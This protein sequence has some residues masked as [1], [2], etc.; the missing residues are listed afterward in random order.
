MKSEDCIDYALGEMPTPRREA[1]ERELAESPELLQSLEETTAWLDTLREAS[2]PTEALDATRREFLLAACRSNISTR[3]RRAKIIRL[4]VPLSLAAVALFGLLLARPGPGP[5]RNASPLGAGSGSVHYE[6][7][8]S[9][10]L[11]ATARIQN[12]ESVLSQ[13]ISNA[14]SLNKIPPG[15]QLEIQKKSECA[16]INV[17]KPA[18]R[19]AV[20]TASPRHT[21]LTEKNPFLDTKK[22]PEVAMPLSDSYES[23]AQIRQDILDGKLP[24]P[25]SIRIDELLN[26]FTYDFD[27]PAVA[28]GPFAVTLEAGKSP[29]NPDRLLVK[30]GLKISDPPAGSDLSSFRDIMLSVR[31]QPA[32]VAS[33]RLI[34]YEKNNAP[35]R[36][37][38]RLPFAKPLTVTAL[39][40]IV[41]HARTA[42]SPHDTLL[43][44]IVH[45]RTPR[46]H[47]CQHMV[48]TCS[49]SGIPPL[50]E[51][52][53][54]YRFAAA[55]AA[56]GMKLAGNPEAENISWS[57]IETL[58]ANSLGADPDGQRADFT[59]LVAKASRLAA[60]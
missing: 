18:P 7:V 40:E 50:E 10:I 1:F 58:A 54:D 17:E 6:P 41:P 34:G 55:V 31:F 26:A 29:W 57:A 23:Y 39:Y 59:N 53:T 9:E 4:A 20:K 51:S 22:F 36:S 56:F 33:H 14:V 19:L 60:G 24:D 52:S 3:R 37:L 30:V 5:F 21:R 48:T 46:H 38:A 15:G 35:A 8:G 49:A 13:Q 25:A 47:S 16:A 11:S 43:T 44:A 2:R 45:Y 42:A 12:A 32:K 28:S 27:K